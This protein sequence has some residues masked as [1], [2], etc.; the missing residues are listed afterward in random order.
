MYTSASKR[1]GGRKG[2]W[3]G[4]REGGRERRKRERERG[5]KRERENR[6]T[7]A[8]INNRASQIDTFPPFYLR[9]STEKALSI[10]R[11]SSEIAFGCL[12]V[13]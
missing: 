1:E 8:G 12:T 9:V 7:K 5:R 10:L 6:A 2:G 3:E 11:E 13:G 4:G